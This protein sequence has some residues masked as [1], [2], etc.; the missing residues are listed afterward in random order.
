MSYPATTRSRLGGRLIIIA[1]FA[2]LIGLAA[3]VR[4]EPDR[5][6]ERRADRQTAQTSCNQIAEAIGRFKLDVQQLPT[7]FRGRSS[8]G[9]LHGPG[10]SPNFREH[11]D[12]LPGQLSWFL[13]EN[14]MAGDVWAGPYMKELIPDPWGRQYIIR[15]ESLWQLP[16]DHSLLNVW[17]LS[18]GENGIVETAS[19]DRQ[20]RGDDVGVNLPLSGS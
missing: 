5:E 14:Y 8:Y 2:V 7:G 11:P 16:E 9:W 18:A 3:V 1:T 6:L 10:V 17:V 4:P 20:L 12:G 15:A 19:G 13:Q